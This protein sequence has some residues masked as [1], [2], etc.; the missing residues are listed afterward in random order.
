MTGW[1][2]KVVPNKPLTAILHQPARIQAS[3]LFSALC[4]TEPF[5]LPSS[6]ALS[7]RHARNVPAAW[8]STTP[9][10]STYEANPTTT[11]ATITP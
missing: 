1:R 6:P 4:G 5:L 11:K 7:T 2:L 3:G 10:N 9:S 8:F